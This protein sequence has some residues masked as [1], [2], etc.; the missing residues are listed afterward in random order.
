MG[1]ILRRR[2]ISV[3]FGPLSFLF[4]RM[5]VATAALA[6]LLACYVV[7]SLILFV[8]RINPSLDGRSDEH[9]AADSVTYIYI[10]D[11]LREGRN[12]PFALTAM[13]AFP[14]TVW[15]PVLLT[16]ALRS[17]FAIVMVNYTMLLASVLLFKRWLH[18]STGAFMALLLLNPTTTISLLSVNKEM[19]DLLGVSLCL[20]AYRTHRHGVL[21]ASLGLAFVN[22]CEVC[23]VMVI[24]MLADSRLNPWRRKRVAT[25]TLL[26]LVLSCLLPVVGSAALSGRFEEARYAGLVAQLDILEMHYLYALAVLPKVAE[27]LFGEL[28][29]GLDRSYILWFNNLADVIV[30]LILVMRHL[31]TLRNDIIYF[32]TLGG[33]LMA[34]SL[35]IQPRYFYFIYALLCLQ[36][37]QRRRRHVACTGTP[38]AQTQAL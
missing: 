26:I 34:V 10:A 25:T 35:V 12:D 28:A 11:A 33:A 22:R 24:F 37:A 14:N 18:F 4:K 13:A 2:K 30:L 29:L 17:T 7:F 5:T 6:G 15:F 31:L 32:C 9:I 36:A 21:V 19:V 27:N 23:A 3:T 8:Q 16:L 20:Y 38:L 1:A